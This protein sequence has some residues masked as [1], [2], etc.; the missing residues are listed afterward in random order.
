[1]KDLPVRF[2]KPCDEKWE[3]MTPAG[4]DRVCARCDTLIHDL[5]HYEFD[6]AEALL[7]SGS[8]TCVRARVGADG[9]VALKP[10]RGM[11]RMVVAAGA[12]AGLLAAA[13]PAAAQQDRSGG[14][15]VGRVIFPGFPTRVTATG[16][17]GKTFRSHVRPNGEYRFKRVPA[18]TYTLTFEPDCGDSWVVENVVVRNDIVLAPETEAENQCIVVGMLLVDDGKGSAG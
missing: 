8:E 7:R 1:M 14:A 15:I 17:D 10:G 11:R 18:D 13:Q 2:P 6:A 4:C 9:V 16:Q 5:S 3:A 12:L